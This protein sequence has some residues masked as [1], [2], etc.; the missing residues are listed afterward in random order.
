MTIY[1]TTGNPAGTFTVQNPLTGFRTDPDL[2]YDADPNTGVAVYAPY[3]LETYYGVPAST[4]WVQVGGTSIGSP[5]LSAFAAIVNQLRAADGKPS[6]DG[7]SQFLPAIYQINNP[8][9]ASYDP[10]AFQD[11][12][13]GYN[14]YYTPV[15]ATTWSRAGARPTSRIS[16]A[17]SLATRAAPWRTRC[18]GPAP[19]AMRAGMTQATGR[20]AIPWEALS[21]AASCRA[22]PIS[23]VVDLSNQTIVLGA[24][25]SAPGAGY[26]TIASL[27]VTGTNDGIDLD[28]GTLDLSGNPTDGSAA[29][30]NFAVDNTGDF[31][32]LQGGV[33]KDAS[34]A[35]GTP[36]TV[37][38]GYS[39]YIDS[40]VL[41]GT[42]E[43]QTGS[44]LYLL[45]NWINHG[46][47]TALYGAN[48]T[49]GSPWQAGLGD[50][51]ASLAKW[52]TSA[53]S[54]KTAAAHGLPGRVHDL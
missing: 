32:V 4:P 46:T 5:Q 36:I 21:P 44:S 12:T 13:T 54:P 53:R 48:L 10:T 8:S 28:A 35:A 22:P 9:S 7:A 38:S 49:L 3:A 45:G 51:N 14:G 30:G 41:N 33:L 26:D 37:P 16:R 11:I 50:P 47:I 18:T 43:A 2:S 52:R 25:G 29:L 31:V 40:G 39:G 23:V 20:I 34:I 19:P 15:R 42:V 6:L 24:T 17:I 1:D 27:S